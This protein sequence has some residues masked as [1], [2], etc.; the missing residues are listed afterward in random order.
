MRKPSPWHG[1]ELI[2]AGSFDHVFLYKDEIFA[3]SPGKELFRAKLSEVLGSRSYPAPD[4]RSDRL[5]EAYLCNNQQLNEDGLQ[6]F[7]PPRP[8]ISDLRVEVD[9][10]AWMLIADLAADMGHD[11]EI[12]DI[13]I[14]YDRLYMSTTEGLWHIDFSIEANKDFHISKP[15]RRN[16]AWCISATA[17]FG[18]VAASCADDGLFLGYDDFNELG[19]AKDELVHQGGKSHRSSWIRRDLINYGWGSQS[20]LLRSQSSS[21]PTSGSSGGQPFPVIT[22][23]NVANRSDPASGPSL[24][25]ADRFGGS[26]LVY[27]T[28]NLFIAVT[29]GGEMVVEDRGYTRST[30]SLNAGELRPVYTGVIG[31]PLDAQRLLHGTDK[32][33]T[34]TVV[35]H[36]LQG[37][38]AV[39]KQGYS[40]LFDQHAVSI[41]TFPSSKRYK[42]LVGIVAEDHIRLCSPTPSFFP[43]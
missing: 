4:R 21:V 41:K 9:S 34:Y 38:F 28:E 8:N 11:S 37:V 29:S 25:L 30:N 43:A 1:A 3:I 20:Q 17:K 12:L 31:M 24:D 5:I 33:S 15:K 6:E 23:F 39:S 40:Q 16:D 42:N 32:F 36:T 13:T 26:R 18:C 7:I 14:Y 22:T 2:I 35:V 19:N 27:N 10:V